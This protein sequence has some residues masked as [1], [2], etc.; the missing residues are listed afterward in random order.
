MYLQL[1]EHVS[2]ILSFQTPFVAGPLCAPRPFCVRLRQHYEL[3]L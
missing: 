2:V 3:V 1:A